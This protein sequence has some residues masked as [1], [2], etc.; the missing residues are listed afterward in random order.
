MTKR[1]LSTWAT[2]ACSLMLVACGGGSGRGGSDVA[3][4]GTGPSAQ[5]L[6]GELAVFIMT[7]ANIGDN[8]ANTVNL[9]NL[10]G[11]QLALTGIT[12][13]ASGGAVC[14]ET[15]GVTMTITSLPAGG[16][17]AFAVS[18][19]VASGANGAITNTMS[20][21]YSEDTSRTNNSS[22][23]SGVA[24][25][26]TGNLVVTGVGPTG[27]VPGGGAADFVMTV[28][29]DGPDAASAVSLVDEVGNNLTVTAVQCNGTGGAVCPATLGI[30][31]NVDTLPVGGALTFTISTTV[32]SGTSG[33]ISNTLTATAPN[34]TDRTDSFAVAT[35]TAYTARAGVF[36]TGVGPATVIPAGN[37][38]TFTM[39]VS[40]AG[41]DVATAVHI[42]N[43][44]SGNITQ[45]GGTCVASG[46]AVCPTSVAPVMDVATLPVSGVLT[47]E[48][49]TLVAAGT[50]GSITNTMTATPTNDPDRSDNS[51][52]A[53]G[54]ASAYNL[55][56][57]GTTPPPPSPITGGSTVVFTMVVSNAGPGLALAVPITD[58]V[59]SNLTIGAITCVAGGG[60]VCPASLGP[61]MVAPSIPSSGTLTFL[62][63]TIVTAGANG[64]VSNSMTATGAGDSRPNDNTATAS[65]TAVSADLGVSQTAANG[66][67]PVG[68]GGTAV[69]TAV[70]AN[71]GP[72]AAANVTITETLT[73][74]YAASVTC[75]AAGGSTC[76]AGPLGP[77]ISVASLPAGSRLTL[78]YTVPVAST[79]RG[80]IVNLVQV[81]GDADPNTDNNSAS[82]TVVAVD[83]RN[84]AYKAFA[85]DGREYA[86]T[87]DFDARTY[88]MAGNGQSVQRTFT[89]DPNGDF[90][91]GGTSRFRTG[92]DL[93][94]GGHDFGGGVLPYVAGRNFGTSINELGSAYNLATRNLPTGGTAITHAGTARASGNVLQ[95]C[96]TDTGLPPLPQSCASADLKNYALSVSGDLYTGQEVLSGEVL[97][98]RLAHVGASTVLLSAGAA[99]DG[100]QRLMIGLPDAASLVGG[101]VYGGST[102]GDWV[103][104]SL[105]VDTYAFAGANGASD[106]ALL[107]RI[108]TGGPFA[109]WTGFRVS[110]SQRIYVMQAS[111][112]VVTFGGFGGGASGLLQVAV[113]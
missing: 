93:V 11:N 101:T 107:Q 60:A 5:V 37:P 98:F 31:M 36:V 82:V 9:V 41:P 74:G 76:P 71:P 17:L 86:M 42:V 97:T 91:V 27:T 49:T 24:Y 28:R 70:V 45:T 43:T 67:A 33:V 38:A 84:G 94:V 21:S 55:I 78:T 40:N 29:N 105:G 57:S 19:R 72:G 51:A 89:A 99:P 83:T 15:V 23:A 65:A 7:V 3:V 39:T 22:T 92:T 48:I 58:T 18:A 30:R 63:P 59:S 16:S 77:V 69:F 68:A 34:D 26:L 10:V 2:L 100:T 6:G 1:W 110:D 62:V 90:T 102:T 109:M 4:T 50:N 25:S 35:G 75:V 52:V 87:V 64:T 56:A 61:N 8:P 81:T 103:T 47:F 79:Q 104:I 95:V 73:A 112:L 14:P 46:G 54:T 113:P 44:V 53:V 80:D 13:S 88:T 12:C 106:S 32:A 96:Q 66:G 111:P 108:N 20:A 85:A